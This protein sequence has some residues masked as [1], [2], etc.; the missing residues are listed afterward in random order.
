MEKT[1][2]GG[3]ELGRIDEKMTEKFGPMDLGFTVL[4]NP[5]IYK[6]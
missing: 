5:K 1:V 3:N 4:D 2:F 6:D